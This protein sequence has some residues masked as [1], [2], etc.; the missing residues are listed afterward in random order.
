[1]KKMSNFKQFKVNEITSSETNV[2]TGGISCRE[3]ELVERYLR[4]TGQIERADAV[5]E[6]RASPGFQCTEA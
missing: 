3:A 6:M 5:A 2:L 4:G 1:M